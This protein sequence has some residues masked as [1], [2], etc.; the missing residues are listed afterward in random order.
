MQFVDLLMG[1]EVQDM[2]GM[3]YG[4]PVNRAAFNSVGSKLIDAQNATLQELLRYYDEDML[5]MY[6]YTTD[7][8]DEEG[9]ADFAAM[10]ETLSGW[11][12]NDGAINAIIR[13]EMPA[14]FEGQKTLDQVIPV[15]ED[16]VQTILNERLG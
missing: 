10:I 4:I 7:I 1:D 16:R 12:T 14:Y 2:F 8:M 11:Y 15:V 13:E 6:G 3:N 9:I 5:R